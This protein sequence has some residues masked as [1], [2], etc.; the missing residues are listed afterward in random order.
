MNQPKLLGSQQPR[1]D[2][3]QDR[4]EDAVVFARQAFDLVLLDPP[5][6]QGWLE[7]VAPLLSAIA[8]PGMKVYAEAEHRIAALGD[9]QTR[10]Q[11]QAGQ[12]YYHLLEHSLEQLEHA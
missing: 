4:L 8:R 10:K 6:R 3:G 12:V 1:Q 2:D 9:W 7:K 11:G 5:Y